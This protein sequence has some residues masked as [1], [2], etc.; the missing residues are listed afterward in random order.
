MP[1]SHV[2]QLKMNIGSVT[3]IER[4]ETWR[5]YSAELIA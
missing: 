4:E 1:I 3:L 5:V 2:T